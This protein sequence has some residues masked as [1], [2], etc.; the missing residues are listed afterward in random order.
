MIIC[1][2]LMSMVDAILEQ[3]DFQLKKN[4]PNY[5]NATKHNKK[6]NTIKN[7]KSQ[8]NIKKYQISI[9]LSLYNQILIHSSNLTNQ[10][11]NSLVEDKEITSNEIDRDLTNSVKGKFLNKPYSFFIFYKLLT[12]AHHKL[13][14]FAVNFY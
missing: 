8:N 7:I 10:I 5:S 2:L 3:Q 11:M 4:L 6:S 1:N 12:S 14:S 9:S 13:P